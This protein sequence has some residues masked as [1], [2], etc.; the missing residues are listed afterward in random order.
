MRYTLSREIRLK[1]RPVGVPELASFELAEVNLPVPAQDEILVQNIWMTVDPY[2]RFQMIDQNQYPRWELGE[3][4]DGVA[5]GR[6]VES[7]SARFQVGDFV[8]SAL[9]WREFFV[10]NPDTP[11]NSRIAPESAHASVWRVD[12]V[13]APLRTYMGALGQTGHT[14][15]AGLF[16]IA[17][18]KG[19]ETVF[20]SAAA[21]AVGSVACQ[22]AKAMACTVIGSAGSDEKCAWLKNVAKVDHAINYQ[23]VDN[24]RAALH[25]AAPE[26]INIYFDNVGGEHLVAAI[27]NMAPFG[28]IAVCGSISQYNATSKPAGPRNFHLVVP[29]R[30]RVEGFDGSDHIGSM[31]RFQALAS[32]WIREGRLHCQDTVVEGIENAPRAFIG[33]F[34][35][36]NIGKMLVKLGPDAS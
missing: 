8:Q 23:K 10:V 35:G 15:Y 6:V 30:I 12:P 18:L 2:M 21:G 26:G 22:I 1:E 34:T 14:A 5:I 13:L 33:L 36:E 31:P 20:I 16:E 9:G 28:R 27:A 24:L 17:G 25:A 19:G 32:Q 11:G 3:V 7:R 4:L 29:K